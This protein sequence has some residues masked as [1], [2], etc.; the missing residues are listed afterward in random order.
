MQFSDF[1]RL[2]RFEH[3]IMLVIAV[4]IGETVVLGHIPDLTLPIL[5][6]LLVP[7]FSEM[8]SFALNDYLD[9]ESD[10]LNKKTERPLVRGTISRQF[11]FRFAWISL[12]V[13][14]ALAF[15]VNY[16]AFI[17]ALLFN[18]LAVLYNYKLKDMPVLGNA[19]IAFAMAIPFIFGN[20]VVSSD[21]R[22]VATVLAMLGF[23]SGLAREIVKSAQDME[24]DLLARK[25]RTL[26]ILIGRGNS[27]MLAILLYAF[28][29]PFS[30]SPFAYGL[31]AAPLPIIVLTVANLGI[32]YNILLVRHAIQGAD[33]TGREYL[34]K[35]RNITLVSL[36]AGLIG[37][38]M[39][40]I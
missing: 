29:I 33:K 6:S 35:A 34:K 22:A 37:Y 15:F 30:Y 12:A 26:P 27:L 18:A 38:L 23:I 24:G 28:F 39:A 40:V 31:K 36:F 10:R 25:A 7:L 20:F 13:S 3:A 2:V 19:Y 9:V 11:A 17:I 21:L 16:H 1:L 5:L 32:I 4:F 8:G 14:V